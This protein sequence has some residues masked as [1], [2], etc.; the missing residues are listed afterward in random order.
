VEVILLEKVPQLGDL[1]TK[2]KVKAGFGR[3]YLIP[4]GKALSATK[5][6]V[7][8]FEERRIELFALAE[9]RLQKSKHRVDLINGLLVKIAANASE[10]GKLFGSVGA[11]EI[12]RALKELGHECAKHEVRLLDGP[13]RS[14]GEFDVELQL[15]GDEVVA[16]IK[17]SIVAA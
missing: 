11:H 5:A 4:T 3:N 15:L 1:G 8:F 16:K 6:N 10:E 12:V 2:V 7:K 9:E 14:L 13:I 17:V